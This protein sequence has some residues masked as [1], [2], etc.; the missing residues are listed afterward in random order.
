M[1]ISLSWIIDSYARLGVATFGWTWTSLYLLSNYRQLSL[2]YSSYARASSL[3]ARP[4]SLVGSI[5]TSVGALTCRKGS[6]C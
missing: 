3:S 4:S 2:S 5:T 1:L 6:R